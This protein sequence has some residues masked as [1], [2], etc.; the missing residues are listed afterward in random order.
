MES[1]LEK[2]KNSQLLVCQVNEKMLHILFLNV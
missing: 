2:E 1:F